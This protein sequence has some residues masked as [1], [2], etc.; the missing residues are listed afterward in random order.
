MI[1]DALPLMPLNACMHVI[2]LA[3]AVLLYSSS[4]TASAEVKRISIMN[5]IEAVANNRKYEGYLSLND[6]IVH[7]ILHCDGKGEELKGVNII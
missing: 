5:A 1:E 3:I 7:L 2:L 4:A 6:S